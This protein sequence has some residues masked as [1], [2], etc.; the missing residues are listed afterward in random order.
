[1]DCAIYPGTTCQTGTDPNGL[2]LPVCS[3]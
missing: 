3:S 2:S 1:L